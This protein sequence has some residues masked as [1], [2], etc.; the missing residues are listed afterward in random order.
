[1][2]KNILVPLDGSRLAESAL[3]PA[4][5]LA[6]TLN[7][8]VTLLHVIE[9]D[10]PNQIHNDRH[11]TR[12]DEATAYL[13]KLAEQAAGKNIAV[14]TH[15]HSAEVADVAASITEHVREDFK[16][17][18]IVMCAH[19][20]SGFRDLIFGSI[21]QQVLAEGET[22]LLLLQPH[23]AKSAP[24]AL[25]RIL[26]PL[27]SESKHDDTLPYALNL[28]RAYQ[29]EI[30]LLTVISTFDTLTGKEAAISSL[31]PVTATAL[32]DLLEE[33][34]KEHLQTHLDEFLQAG[35]NTSA[36]IGRG[37]PASV[38]SATATRLHADLIL[39]STHRKAGV[40]AFWA[41]SVAPNVVKKTRIPLLLIPLKEA[42]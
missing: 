20:S 22:P 41:R 31:L 34:A 30:H 33:N 23:T 7:A 9:K 3:P 13:Q 6:E 15:V 17:D 24:F 40:Q 36:E 10:A 39:I 26:I 28:A 2:F 5:S 29:A 12:S 35:C 14:T 1:M 18:L 32:L 11:L 4:F 19:G 16:P 25:R 37:D 21:A 38:I 42:S 27:D 8:P